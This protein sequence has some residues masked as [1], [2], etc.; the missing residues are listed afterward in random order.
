VY[1]EEART[2]AGHPNGPEVWDRLLSE[3][4][5]EL[6]QVNNHGQ[7]RVNSAAAELDDTGVPWIPR[8]GG[9]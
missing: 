2:V 6:Q 7:N 1:P 4:A 5:A 3:L 9:C 8:L